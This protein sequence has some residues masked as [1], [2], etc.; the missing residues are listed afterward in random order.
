M[1]FLCHI[2]INDGNKM[3]GKKPSKL[4]LNTFQK[5]RTIKI[6]CFKFHKNQWLN[7]KFSNKKLGINTMVS[8]TTHHFYQNWLENKSMINF[9]EEPYGQ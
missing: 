3:L 7:E 5:W 4:Y 2:H 6:F 9:S 8:S 1:F